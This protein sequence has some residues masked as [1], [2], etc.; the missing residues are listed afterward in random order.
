M[1]ESSCDLCLAV[2]D[3]LETLCA[4]DGVLALVPRLE[5]SLAVGDVALDGDVI[6]LM[7]GPLLVLTVGLAFFEV[8]GVP[9]IREAPLVD[10]LIV[11]RRVSSEALQYVLVRK[12]LTSVRF[13]LPLE[14]LISEFP[15]CNSSSRISVILS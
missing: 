5:S 9:V 12:L 11:V 14:F 13:K 1:L 15:N 10:L 3:G 6:A 4:L 7:L 2:S 8:L